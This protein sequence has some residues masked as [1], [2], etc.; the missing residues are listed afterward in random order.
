MRTRL[1]VLAL[2]MMLLTC[3][4]ELPHPRYTGHPS[5]ALS[6]IPYPPPPARVE[7]V[8][9]QPVDDAVYVRGE[10]RWDGRRWAWKQGAWYVP[11]PGALYARW[12]TVRAPDGKLYIASGTWRDAQGKEVPAPEPATGGR[13]GSEAVV[14]AEGENE[15]V[16]QTIP[17]DGGSPEGGVAPESQGSRRPGPR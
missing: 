14:N 13:S 7:M 11:R 17:P 1:L 4:S 2:S 12:V 5:S 16:G 3:S 10:W 9:D 15:A 6:E 8:A